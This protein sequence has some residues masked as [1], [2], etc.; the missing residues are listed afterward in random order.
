M[1]GRSD[2]GTGLLGTLGNIAWFILAGWWLALGHV[3]SAV[4][5]V[6]TNKGI[7]VG[8]QHRKLAGISLAPIG[9]TVV[10]I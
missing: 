1:T 6:V 8:I 3:L 10:R 4:A 2:I 5:C 7:P 9:M